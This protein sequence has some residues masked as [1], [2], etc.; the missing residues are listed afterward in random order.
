MVNSQARGSHPGHRPRGCALVGLG[1]RGRLRALPEPHLP[2]RGGSAGLEAAPR[3]AAHHARAR[4]HGGA[5]ARRA[6][7]QRPD[8]DRP[9]ATRSAS[10]TSRPDIWDIVKWPVIL[11]IVVVMVAV[12]YYATPNVQAARS[13]GGSRSA[14]PSPSASGCSPRS[15]SASTSRNFSPYN[16]TLRLGRRHHRLPAVAVA[17]QP[18]A[19]LR[20][21]DRRRAASG[22]ASCRPASGPSRPSSCRR[23]TPAA[24]TRPRRSW[25][26]GSPRA[27]ACG[28]EAEPPTGMTD[29]AN[30]Y[31][32]GP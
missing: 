28:C 6:R 11:G 14:R 1:L 30:G 13:S 22:P 3:R 18:R 24:P 16:K 7:G 27:A 12:L 17:H 10:A 25:P 19:A 23:A 21:R 4:R 26:S 32:R 5:R 29:D 31:V 2:G 9:S 20:G 15:A 8:R